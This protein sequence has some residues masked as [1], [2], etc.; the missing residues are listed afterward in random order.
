MT[1]FIS[2]AEKKN[3]GMLSVDIPFFP[4]LHLGT[5]EDKIVLAIRIGN[6]D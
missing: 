6:N 4:T 3:T 1:L 5:Q 2:F